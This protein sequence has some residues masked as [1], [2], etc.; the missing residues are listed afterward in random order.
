MRVAKP[1]QLSS[2]DDRRL[3]ILSKRKRVEARVQIRSRIV[4]LAAAGMTDKDI[5]QKLDIGRRVVARWRARFL[6]AGVDGLLQDATR[7]GR[8]RTARNA[9]NVE[10]V[11][12]ITLENTPAGA[13]HWS[14]RTLAAH[15]GTSASAVA[16]IWRAHGLKPHRVESFKLSNDTHFIEKL[17][18]IV[19][20]YLDPPEHALV[21]C[22]DEKTQI[23]A[24]DRTQPGLPLKRGRG[25]TMTHDYK[26]NGV[27][28]LFAVLN[29]LD[30]KVLSMT[31]PLHRH[32]EWLKFLKMID[33]KTPKTKDLHLVVDNYATHKHP[34]VK[35]WLAKHP[36]FHIHFTLT[37]SSWLNIVERFFRDITDKRIRRG[38][39]ASVAELEAAINEYIAVHNAK[40][41]PFIW[42]AKASDILAKVTR[43]RTTLNKYTSN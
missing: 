4:L 14:T 19:G 24:L 25:R 15:L 7:P 37:S 10:Q 3:R 43:A 35:A 42:T 29:M 31:D 18:D 30:G 22:C 1:I 39:F 9:V 38:A 41:K 32:Q 12:R 2:D 6:A 33:R 8:P 40:P 28:T 11:V 36:R 34:E 17:E 23:Q 20:L 21:L 26:R 13:T 16:R 27:M 5:A